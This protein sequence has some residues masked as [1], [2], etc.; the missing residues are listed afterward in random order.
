VDPTAAKEAEVGAGAA[1]A[2]TTERDEGFMGGA[3]ARCGAQEWSER[4]AV[5]RW[6]PGAFEPHATRCTRRR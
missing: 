2:L 5:W 6:A 4:A 1:Q 3:G